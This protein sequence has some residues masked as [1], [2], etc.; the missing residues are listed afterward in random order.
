M[1]PNL[2][3]LKSVILILARHWFIC[4]EPRDEREDAHEGDGELQVA[5]VADHVD[6]EAHE[7]GDGEADGVLD[8]PGLLAIP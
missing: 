6:D 2:R 8:H 1:L 5:P 4:E 7:T 3:N